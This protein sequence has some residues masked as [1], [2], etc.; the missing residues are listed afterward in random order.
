MKKQHI[1]LFLFLGLLIF[2][3]S[4]CG[5][6]QTNE[7]SKKKFQIWQNKT[8]K[9]WQDF[10]KLEYT[11]DSDGNLTEETARGVSG[12]SLVNQ[13]RFSIEYNKKG[14]I[15]RRTRESWKGDRWA[16]AIQNLYTYKEDRV[17]QRKDSMLLQNKPMVSSVTYKYN[18]SGQLISEMGELSKISAGI[19]QRVVYQYDKN[20][21][22][23]V[24]E[25]PVFKNEKWTNSRKMILKYNQEGHHIETIRYNW[26][27][28]EWVESIRYQMT[29]DKEGNRLSELWKKSTEQG[30]T[31]FMRVTYQYFD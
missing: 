3:V 6:A 1:S 14:Q 26:K 21:H 23:T 2:G 9:G 4:R 7:K 27:K 10:R 25:F 22:P 29:V 13:Y 28:T 16:F 5:N 15:L 11:Y 24:K 19:V 17:L 18:N 31:D 8:E 30:G 12:D 20:Q